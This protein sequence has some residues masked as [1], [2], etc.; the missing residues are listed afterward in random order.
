MLFTTLLQVSLVSTLPV[1][2]IP[3]LTDSLRQDVVI[4]AIRSSENA[5]FTQTIINKKA[6]ESNYH[7]A[8]LPYVLHASPS[9]ISQSDAGNGFGYSY[10]RLRGID[11]TRINF[12]INGIPINDPENHGFFSNNFADL[13]SSASS[14][15]IQRGVGTSGNGTAP[16]AGSVNLATQDVRDPQFSKL[17]L[18]YGSFDSRRITLEHNTG[19]NSSS[20]FGVYA[21]ASLLSSDGFR[22][23]SGSNM[24]TFFFSGGYFGKKGQ[25]KFNVFGGSSESQLSY[26]AV[27]KSAL[28]SDYRTNFNSPRERDA[29]QQFFYQLQ[30]DYKV[31][32]R[33]NLSA[34]GYYV[35]GT[36][37]KF[38][39]DAFNNFP[40]PLYYE[41]YN[42]PDP[43][44][45]PFSTSSNFLVNYR[46]EQANWGAMSIGNYKTSKLN[47]TIGLHANSFKA[48]HF[49]EVL[50]ADAFPSGYKTG[51]IAYFNTGFKRELSTF[52]KLNYVI[53][54]KISLFTDA[55]IKYTDFSYDYRK[56]PILVESGSDNLNWLFFNPKVG[57]NVEV[58][59]IISAYSSFG[60]TS[61]E[62]ARL[63]MFQGGDY[64]TNQITKNNIPKAETVR[65]FEIGLK[66]KNE[67]VNFALNVYAM[68]FRNEI[69]ATGSLNNFG[70]YLRQNVDESYRRGF[71]AEISV[72]FLKKFTFKNST[73][74][75]INKIKSYK[76]SFLIKDSLG[77][78][79]F[80][81][82]GNVVSKEETFTNVT[83]VLTPNFSTYN[84]ISYQPNSI[85][86]FELIGRFVGE[87]YLDNTQNKDLTTP[88]YFVSDLKA[89]VKLEKIT[90]LNSYIRLSVNNIFDTKYYTSGTPSNWI[91]RNTN[92]NETRFTESNYFV[93]ALRNVMVTAGIKF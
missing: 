10:F 58:S 78:K 55:Q 33:I 69:A 87:M 74:I 6:I 45:T 14:I 61:R 15:Q 27:S 22:R 9:I 82:N 62:P 16:I 52:L 57:M 40:D 20:K 68:E 73:N 91:N 43:S 48:D 38:T 34:M 51:H 46:L 31:S 47:A 63:D 7:G 85:F 29:F 83:P 71:E 1:D 86:S 56:Q 12:N 67:N 18:G 77:N 72:R 23:N 92:V 13:A 49:I 75:S 30:Y 60:I 70:Y 66:Y 24:K 37:P 53:F 41:Y 44:G 21:R 84:S 81:D 54:D 90:K 93:G 35:Q 39:Y 32:N 36:A 3:L 5:P 64:A 26:Y 65:N 79:T 4:T 59:S 88:A 19:I 17:T 89:E 80:D 42:L 25:L 50:D 28:E 11:F 2:T 8:D 76:Q